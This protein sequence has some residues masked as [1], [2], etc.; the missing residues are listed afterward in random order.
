MEF[1][2]E[3]TSKIEDLQVLEKNLQ[4]LLMEKQSFQVELNESNNALEELTK[5]SKEVYKIIG[6]VMILSEKNNLISELNEKKKILELRFDSIEKQEKI[7]S[8]KV[9]KIRKEIDKEISDYNEKS[10]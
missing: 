10:K 6:G 1:S 8:E 3:T 9:E 4:N 2:K 5:S 7:F